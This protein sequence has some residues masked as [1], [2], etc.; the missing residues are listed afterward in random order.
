MTLKNIILS[1]SCLSLTFG[2]QSFA[3]AEKGCIAL[4][5]NNKPVVVEVELPHFTNGIF[6]TSQFSFKNLPNNMVVDGKGRYCYDVTDDR[7]AFVQTYYYAVTAIEDY[8]NIFSKLRLPLPEKLVWTLTKDVE[9]PTTGYTG[10]TSG[11]ISYPTPAMIDNTSL[12]HEIGHWVSAAV[13]KDDDLRK[14]NFR[15]SNS[16]LAKQDN[17]YA[18]VTVAEGSADILSALHTGVTEI[19]KYDCYENTD[20]LDEFVRYPDL[21]PTLRTGMLKVL[22]STRFS[23]TYPKYVEAIQDVL[24]T[25][26]P[27]L[28]LPFYYFVSH[29][30]NQPLW[31]AAMKF[32]VE[33]VKLV[34]IKTLSTFDTSKPYTY[35]DF[36]KAI[37]QNAREFNPEMGDFL[38]AEYEKRGIQ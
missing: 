38:E 9:S 37:T 26:P 19:G 14:N 34:Y 33:N 17:R 4:Y 27:S 10:A 20:D 29:L 15:E 23:A 16:L 22:S 12:S 35:S 8:N 3:R 5:Q 32:G 18:S 6:T 7:F 11:A 25:N 36:V 24:K 13:L 28:D 30:A 1:I 21:L 31:Q 2:F